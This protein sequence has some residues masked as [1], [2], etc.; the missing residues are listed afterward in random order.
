[1]SFAN[2]I[3][4]PWSGLSTLMTVLSRRLLVKIFS[5]LSCPRTGQSKFSN[6]VK[7]PSCEKQ[8]GSVVALSDVQS[9]INLSSSKLG[10]NTPLSPPAIEDLGLSL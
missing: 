2:F 7:D 3:I 9:I 10:V 4:E 8:T 5:G 6:A 1:M